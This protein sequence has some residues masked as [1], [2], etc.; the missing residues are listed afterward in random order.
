MRLVI[1]EPAGALAIWRLKTG[2]TEN[3]IGLVTNLFEEDYHVPA[4]FES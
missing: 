2:L 1:N 3:L 4:L